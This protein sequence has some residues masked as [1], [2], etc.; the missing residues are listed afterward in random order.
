MGNRKSSDNVAYDN[1]DAISYFVIRIGPL[2]NVPPAVTGVAAA[3]DIS[4]KTTQ[5]LRRLFFIFSI[6]QKYLT[7]WKAL[8]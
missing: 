5:K 3:L 7:R 2:G 8:H 6:K 4:I 1:Y